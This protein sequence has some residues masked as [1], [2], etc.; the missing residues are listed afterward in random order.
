VENDQRKRKL[1]T[2]YLNKVVYR[3]IQKVYDVISESS[4]FLIKIENENILVINIFC[5]LIRKILIIR[6]KSNSF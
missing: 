6:N 3:V 2:V 1:S 5:K 4:G